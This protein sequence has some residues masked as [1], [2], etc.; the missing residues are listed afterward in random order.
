MTADAGTFAAE[1]VAGIAFEAVAAG[2]APLLADHPGYVFPSER[3]KEGVECVL[4]EH[5]IEA[6][7]D[8]SAGLIDREMRDMVSAT[9]IAAYLD[10]AIRRWRGVRDESPAAVSDSGGAPSIA[11]WAMA[12]FYVDAFQSAR[13]SLL[14][15]PLP[16]EAA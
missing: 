15:S 10:A 16:E 3:V 13:V 9:E 5:G 11:P 2:T 12:P 7:D 14:G 4:R 8:G 1:E 6:H